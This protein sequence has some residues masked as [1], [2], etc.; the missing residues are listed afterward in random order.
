MRRQIRLRFRWEET[1]DKSGVDAHNTDK[2]AL[3]ERSVPYDKFIEVIADLLGGAAIT[4]FF[5]SGEP[6]R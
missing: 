2:K 3:S 1:L 5:G 4:S 6:D